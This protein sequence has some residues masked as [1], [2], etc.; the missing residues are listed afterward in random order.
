[1]AVSV[2]TATKDHFLSKIGPAFP[3]ADDLAAELAPQ[4]GTSAPSGDDVRYV[5]DMYIKTDTAKVYIATA[6]DT[7][8]IL[9]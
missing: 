5:G 7:W 9:N 8:T 4:S 2:T 6:S 3:G 1:M